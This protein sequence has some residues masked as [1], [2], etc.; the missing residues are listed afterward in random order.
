MKSAPILVTGVA[1]FVG[2]HVAD[3][4]L[5][6][7]RT[8]VGLDHPEAE[9]D[10][11]RRDRFAQLVGRP[12]FTP[13]RLDIAD[14]E[15]IARLVEEIRPEVIV[16]L[17]AQAGVRRSSET[18]K[19]YAEANLLGFFNILE[20]SRRNGVKH[21]IYAS[22]SSVYGARTEAPFSERD[23]A[24]HPIS[25]YAATK[26]CNELMAHAYSHIHGLP[27]TGLR[28][29]TVYGPWGRP[30]MA[31]FLFVKALFEGRPIDVFNNGDMQRDFTYVDDVTETIA[32]MVEREPV[33]GDLS[34]PGPDRSSG[35]FRVYNIG[36][37]RPVRLLDFIGAVERATGR[38]AVLQFKDM[39][40][41]DVPL[42]AA[43][44]SEIERDFG[45]RP[46]T[47]LD[48]GLG[49]FVEWYRGY[50]GVA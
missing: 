48:V 25:F 1:G 5:R 26:R 11:L 31:A 6:Q 44:T 16:H 18:P 20:A 27:T 15:G 39:Q 14:S 28:F 43:D 24:D 49:R 22:S 2:L 42:T 34:K 46:D 38:K 35:P 33:P 32:R 37:S 36:N 7:G 3:R 12:G 10:P 17:A 19:P 13:V 41:G 30:D 23:P 29:F 4:L 40:P 45:F 21:L 9:N 47:P 8:V 50:F